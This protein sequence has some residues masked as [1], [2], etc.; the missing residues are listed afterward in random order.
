MTGYSAKVRAMKRLTTLLLVAATIFGGSAFLTCPAQ[1]A[2][3]KQTGLSDAEVAE[4]V[5]LITEYRKWSP[6]SL[7]ELAKYEAAEK[8]LISGIKKIQEAH[9]DTDILGMLDSWI[10][11]FTTLVNADKTA[12]PPARGRVKDFKVDG[13]VKGDTIG[14]DYAVRLPKMYKASQAWPLIVAFHDTGSDGEKYIKEVWEQRSVKGLADEFIIVA[15]T[16]GPRTTGRDRAQQKRIEWFDHY[17][18]LNIYWPIR[19]VLKDYNVDTNRIYL[20]GTGVGGATAVQL[21]TLRSRDFAAVAARSALPPRMELLGNL[22]NLPLM[23]VARSDGPFASDE[24]K[25][26]RKGIDEAKAAHEL[27]LVVKEFEPLPNKGAIRKAL[28]S[29]DIDPVHEATA[30]IATFFREHPRNPYP[31]KIR[32]TT[33]TYEYKDLPWIKLRKVDAEPKSDDE[34]ARFATLT[35]A[36]DRE[37]NTI[38]I[39]TENVLNMTVW[40][41]DHLL[42]LSRAVKVKLNGKDFLEKKVDRSLDFLL[43]YQKNNPFDVA[44]AYTGFLPILVPAPEPEPKEGEEGEP[45]EGEDPDTGKEEKKKD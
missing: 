3:A 25:A 14:Y 11:V 21:G 26:A 16:I 4:I 6:R 13:I 2:A 12:S 34:P 38:D 19:E 10:E 39:T 18:L 28:G 15:P 20:E 41:N 31:T 37:S 36:V 22:G 35:A 17:H 42:D 5:D 43:D 33:D 27:E 8:D 1:E 23:I 29:Q 45:K 40:L 7:R 9:G 30:E 32:F 24:G 44:V